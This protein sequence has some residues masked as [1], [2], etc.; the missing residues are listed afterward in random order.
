[1]LRNYF[2]VLHLLG[3][4]KYIKR[5]K[6]CWLCK[7]KWVWSERIIWI[8]VREEM[9]MNFNEAW[10]KVTGRDLQVNQSR[11]CEPQTHLFISANY[12]DALYL[13][14]QSN[15]WSETQKKKLFSVAIKHLIIFIRT[16]NQS[17]VFP[18]CTEN[19][20]NAA[21]LSFIIILFHFVQQSRI[22]RSMDAWS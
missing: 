22:K 15:W 10:R 21:I 16:I 2:P 5:E 18:L 6:K 12:R 7:K 8:S 3:Q 4:V 17:T 11:R 20:G 9:K 13:H 19:K 1:M 14:T